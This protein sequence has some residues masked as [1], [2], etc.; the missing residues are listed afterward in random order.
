MATAR[1]LKS[2]IANLRSNII[3]IVADAMLE[4]KEEITGLLVHQQYDEGIDSEGQ[5]L[6]EYSFAYKTFKRSIG[7]SDRTT[8]SLTGETQ[9][10]MTLTVD[11]P[12]GTFEFISPTTTEEGENKIAWLNKW[13][14]ARGGSDVNKL[15]DD[16]KPL[17]WNIIAP[18]V[19]VKGKELLKLG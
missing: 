17:V 13:N 15:T 14:M 1:E 10:R 19:V 4:H 7:L 9:A 3:G 5:P 2:R 12:A 11:P 8:L 6:R 18:T 16:K